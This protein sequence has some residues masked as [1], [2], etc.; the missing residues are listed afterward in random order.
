MTEELSAEVVIVGAGIA[1]SLC[2]AGLAEQGIDTL[3]VD[4]GPR[5]TRA[6]A[7]ETYYASPDRGKP[8]ASY[9]DTDY[10]PHPPTG[11][12]DSYYVQAGPDHFGATYLRLV[13]GTTWHWEGVCLRLVPDDFRLKSAFGRGV[14]WPISYEDLEPWYDA[15][16]RAIGVAGSAAQLPG[17]PRKTDYP[18]PPMPLSYLDY[19]FAKALAGTPYEPVTTPMARNPVA[20]QGRSAC[21]GSGSC[22]QICPSGAKYDA[23]VHV[24]AAERAGARV[25]AEHIVEKIESDADGRISGLTYK[26][27]DGSQGRVS[28][29]VIVLAAH[30]IETAKILLMSQ[31]EAHP[32]GIANSSDQVGRNLMDHPYKMSWALTQ[33][34][35]WPYRGP[36]SISSVEHTRWS[37]WRA[38]RPAYRISIPTS[39]W[40]WPARAPISTLDALIE[41]G[42]EGEALSKALRDQ[43][44]RQ[45]TLASMTEQLPDPANRIV[46]DFTKRDA[47]GIPRPKIFY[48]HDDYTHRGMATAEEVHK[49]IF[50]RLGVSEQHHAKHPRPGGHLM[51]TYRM[52]ED[53][54]T[55]V[56][57]SDLR[58][59]DHRNLFLLGSGVFPTG[60]AANPTLTIAALALRAVQSIAD[61]LRT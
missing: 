50:S 13:G 22:V 30:G 8:T 36:S 16:E 31:S 40:A 26:R 18:L 29:S 28:A 42:L 39:G 47:L 55:S 46:P 11:N 60:A 57:D 9:P 14:D 2:A 6:Q 19:A 21:C 25:L 20:Y 48:R 44:S 52:G 27:P 56:V 15:A 3:V 4:A 45:V 49:E 41:Q 38:E 51:G 12:T 37:D 24:E 10:A 33:R 32:A 1:G 58:S 23:T 35:V 43:L 59:H 34:P 61:T 54:K 17:S 53:P 7:L 5:I